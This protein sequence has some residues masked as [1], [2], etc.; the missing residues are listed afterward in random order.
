M[1][2]GI[3]SAC[4]RPW[5]IR[6]D[7]VSDSGFETGRKSDF[8]YGNIKLKLCFRKNSRIDKRNGWLLKVLIGV[9]LALMCIFSL[10]FG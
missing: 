5:L 1:Y 10:N 2:V 6:R 9:P 7:I 3:F 8:D 4:I